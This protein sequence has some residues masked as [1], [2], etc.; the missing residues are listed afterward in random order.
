MRIVKIRLQ[1]GVGVVCEAFC[2]LPMNN[3]NRESAMKSIA[4][5][6]LIVMFLGLAVSGFADDRLDKLPP[7]H[8]TWLEEEVVYIITDKEKDLFISLETHEERDYFIEAFWKRRD[9]NPATLENE[10]KTE[11]YERIEYANYHFGREAPMPGWKTDRGR[12]YIILG[13]PEQVQDY[14]GHVDVV[15]C[16]LWLYSGDT[17]LGLPPRFA[18]MFFKKWNVG[19]FRLYDPVGDGPTELMRLRFLNMIS[20]DYQAIDTLARI[21]PDLAKASM[22]IDMTEQL[23]IYAG[24]NTI[25]PNMTGPRA[26][27]ST[28]IVL[29][30]I[31]E[32]PYRAVR[33][34]YTDAYLNYGKRVSAEYSFNYVPNRTYFAVLAG[35]KSTPFVHFSIELDPESFSLQADEEGTKYQTTLDVS[36][37]IK[38]KKGNLV[39]LGDNTVAL[40]LDASQ[41]SQVA[42]SPF[43]YQDNVP[44]LPGEYDISVI[45]RNRATKQYTVAE[46]QLNIE[47]V[48]GEPALS[49]II[50]GYDIELMGGNVTEQTHL[51]FQLGS[52]QILPA[53]E[54][55]FPAGDTV[56]VFCQIL[57][58]T[59]EHWVRFALMDEDELLQEKKTQVVTYAG[60]PA[61]ENFS[62]LKMSGGNYQI[63]A[64]LSDAAGNV[65]ARKSTDL[66]VSPR[67]WIPRAGFV[68]RRGFNAEVPGLLSLARA[69][70]L[71]A[72]GR[73]EEA[74]AEFE[75]AAKNPELPMARW[76]LAGLLLY[77]READRALDLLAPMEADYPNEYEVVE[78]LGLA[79]YFKKDPTQAASYLEKA[80]S[81]RAPDTSVLNA[82]GDSYQKLGKLEDAI[83]VFQRSLELNPEQAG[84]KKRLQS[85]IENSE[86]SSR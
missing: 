84:V 2:R 6:I 10:F 53:M 81:I 70:Q 19:E 26:S 17:S 25:D 54:N 72:L 57:G 52:S 27:L 11:H 44:L 35:P 15:A 62:L 67:S 41:I 77:A 68:Y 3:G 30:D 40:E 9:Q 69:Q 12:Y 78:G 20:E 85:L 16:K 4:L 45:V 7:V 82:L 46:Q 31:E 38:D 59:P 47:P 51:T 74:Q 61:I 13:K 34:D 29:A 33:T 14:E 32:S 24:R 18:L 39:A 5:R 64:E 60:G 1:V 28:P 79:Y 8:R 21:S 83:K 71:L 73:A 42:G 23:N 58:A 49:G 76:K 65:V 75:E 66:V 50:L 80:M 22:T 63:E 37:D 55:S 86:N 43:A 36:M 56:H 48:S